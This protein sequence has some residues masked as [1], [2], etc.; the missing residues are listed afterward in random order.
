[1]P[2]AAPMRP[3]LPRFSRRCTAPNHDFFLLGGVTRTS[4]SA[5]ISALLASTAPSRPELRRTPAQ[6][7]FAAFVTTSASKRGTR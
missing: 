7:G 1:M 3:F 5:C 4:S 2:F 6:Q